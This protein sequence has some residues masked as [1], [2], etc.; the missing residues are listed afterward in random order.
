MKLAIA[1]LLSALSPLLGQISQ[2]HPEYCGI[3]GGINPPLPDISFDIDDR[4]HAVLF[5]GRG[6]STPGIP[7]T[8][9]GLPSFIREAREVC[10][11][12]DGRLV[13]FGYYGG[14]AV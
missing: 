11:L 13:F 4:G 9:Y 8:A 12:S 5:L 2:S 6:S 3:S 7:L 14:T 1:I 10:P